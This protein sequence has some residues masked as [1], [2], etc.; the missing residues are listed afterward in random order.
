LTILT[1]NAEVDK[2]VAPSTRQAPIWV[3]VG[4]LIAAV[5][6]VLTALLRG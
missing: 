6:V 2:V 4:Q 5:I 1:V 3:T